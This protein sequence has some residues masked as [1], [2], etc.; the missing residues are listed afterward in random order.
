[1]LVPQKEGAMY[2]QVDV[3]LPPLKKRKSQVGFLYNFDS[4]LDFSV[5]FQHPPALFKPVVI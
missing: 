2:P 4:A 3:E 5:V 1:M